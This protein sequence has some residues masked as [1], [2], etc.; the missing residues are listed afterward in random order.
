MHKL[1]KI[2]II[3]TNNQT[4]TYALVYIAILIGTSVDCIVCLMLQIK[5]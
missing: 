4:F 1:S 3:I 2:V 5:E